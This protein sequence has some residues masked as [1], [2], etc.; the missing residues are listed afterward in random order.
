MS[1]EEKTR[2]TLKK[3]SE[4]NKLS[5]VI[6]SE[7]GT[8]LVFEDVSLVAS[9]IV[10]I[11]GPNNKRISYTAA[12]IFLQICSPSQG[13]VVYRKAC[14]KYKVPD[15]VK[16]LDK[17]LV[18]GFFGGGAGG[19]AKVDGG[20][21]GGGSNEQPTVG[22]TDPSSSSSLKESEKSS[23]SRPQ[24]DIP[25]AASSSSRK[26]SHSSSTEK[27]HRDRDRDRH[28]RSSSK[29]PHNKKEK[30]HRDKIYD[31]I[32]KPVTNE[33][34]FS[35]LKGVVDKRSITATTP[36][37]QQHPSQDTTGTNTT[38]SA[39]TVPMTEEEQKVDAE[40]IKIRNAL[41][42]TG[43]EVSKLLLQQH[44]KTSQG[45]MQN[46]IPVG[47]SASILR[48]ATVGANLTRVL[49]LYS[50][51]MR[52]SKGSSSKRSSSSSS[53]K[54]GKALKSY[55]IGKKPIIIVPKGSTSP[56][57]M[58]NAQEFFEN[59]KFVSR[60]EI[61]RTKQ[62]RISTS[63]FKRKLKGGGYI[64]F[65][66]VDNPRKIAGPEEWERV[67]AVIALGYSWQFKDWP[68]AFR[69]PV[70]LFTRVFGYFIGMEKDKL[71]SEL[72]GWSCKHGFFHREK[73]GLDS[74]T[75]SAFWNGLDQWMAI[76][77]PE[78]MHNKVED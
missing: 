29:D 41:S 74:I 69:Q 40:M 72:H 68:S 16:A 57:V 6:F 34:L 78:F 75:H 70:Q 54:R 15:P 45:I 22:S 62:K 42:T 36:Q 11:E 63:T 26:R 48:A 20:D 66:I 14:K 64:E 9:Q 51:T 24:G 58:E 61:M 21:G 52:G 23:S 1:E 65:E 31:K 77:K 53:S 67:V 47:N 25:G 8:K 19:A 43:F 50:E 27:H 49:N 76:H 56:I 13:L 30:H 60:K 32:K 37:Q 46:E 73:R 4:G 35:N 2:E 44:L 28:H 5:N 33:Q 3:W 55:L 38:T 59:A 7:D 10:T 12:S 17:P 71:P 39:T 18:V